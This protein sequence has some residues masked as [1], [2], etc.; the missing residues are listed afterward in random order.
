MKPNHRQSYY[1]TPRGL[2]LSFRVWNDGAAPHVLSVHGFG[3]NSFVWHHFACA[4]DNSCCVLAIDLRGHG[5]SEWDCTGTYAIPDFVADV[6]NVLD[7]LCPAPVVLV[8]HSLGAQVAIHAAAARPARIRAVVLVDVGLKPNELSGGYV[9]RKF[10]ERCRVHE[11]V[12]DYIALLRE[13]LPLARRQLLE[14][15]A[16]GAL[17][18]NGEGRYEERCDPMLVNMDDS[19]DTEAML[20]AL[21]QIV[22]PILFVRGAGSAVLSRATARELLA[23]LPQSRVSAVATAGHTVMLDNPEGFCAV[24]KPYVLRFSSRP[25]GEAAVGLSPSL[26]GELPE[27]STQRKTL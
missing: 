16:E 6:V 4:L 18:L 20:A 3:D 13:Q 11:S 23:A 7:D 12:A 15:L 2:N 5:H 9:R 19:V 17:R 8:G 14:V 25:P 26:G 21:K 10:R 22:R 24:V 1:R 27:V